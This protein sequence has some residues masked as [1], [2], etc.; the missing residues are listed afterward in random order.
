MTTGLLQAPVAL[1][2]PAE[3]PRSQA[4]FG[5]VA[6]ATERLEAARA[7]IAT[8]QQAVT[9]TLA[10]LQLARVQLDRA[11]GE[12]TARAAER[13]EAEHR[14]DV[15]DGALQEYSRQMYQQGISPGTATDLL[16]TA[17]P[18]T[19]GQRTDYLRRASADQQTVVEELTDSRD[20][21]VASQA[22]ADASLDEAERNHREASEQR[23]QALRDVDR[24]TEEV[25]TLET[26]VAA[27]ETVLAEA[28]IA[29]EGDEEGAGTQQ[30]VEYNATAEEIAHAENISRALPDFGDLSA[31]E[32]FE[33]Y[34]GAVNGI[35][36]VEDIGNTINAVQ[37]G[38]VEA[39]V[40]QVM[41]AVMAANTGSIGPGAG[42]GTPGNQNPGNSAGDIERVIARGMSQIGTPYVWGGGNAN[43]PT[44]GGFD[45]SGL[46][47][48]AFAGQGIALP[49]FSG[50][51][52][53]AGRRVP[54]GDRQR[55]D[56]VFWGAGGGQHVALYLGNGQM[57][58]AQRSGVPVKVS[59]LRSG[60]Q[61]YAVRM[62][63]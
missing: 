26:E 40:D 48:Y 17:E 46:M 31:I 56:M 38:D 51:Q 28:G 3:Q 25:E 60:Y 2:Q 43:G 54:I 47:V 5:D 6:A 53:N 49:R 8:K 22:D 59:P 10:D 16:S 4:L 34:A 18:G 63:G 44:G 36:S 29:A 37:N 24:V 12:A 1:T 11:V 35:G 52:Y 32:P 58:E 15:A 20:A 61:P 55:G 21:A 14:L 33:L 62:I 23:E 13:S 50:D 57:L 45:C 39:I 42:P 27:L 9:K 7:E 41:N 30:S 19:Q